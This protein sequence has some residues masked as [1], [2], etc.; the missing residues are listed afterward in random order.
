MDRDEYFR[1]LEEASSYNIENYVFDREWV[2]ISGLSHIQ[3]SDRED[4]QFNELNNKVEEENKT[5]KKEKN[6]YKVLE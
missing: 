2:S 4:T 3:K 6:I 1:I 5:T